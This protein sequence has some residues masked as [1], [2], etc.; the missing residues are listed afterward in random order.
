MVHTDS[1]SAEAIAGNEDLLT[2]ILSRIP[3]KQLIKFKSVSKSWLSLISTSTLSRIHTLK[4]P[5][6]SISGLFLRRTPT[7]FQFLPIHANSS[8]KPLF[9]PLNCAS[10]PAGIKYLQSCNG[11][12]LCSSFR[13]LGYKT[14][15]YV[16]NPTTNCFFTLPPFTDESKTAVFGVNLAFEPSKSPYYKVVCIDIYDSRIGAWRLS[17]STFIAPFDMVFD[18][19]VF[20]NGSIVW[21]SPH[22]ASIYFDL[23]NERLNKMSDLPV[24]DNWSKRRFRYFGESCGHLHLMEIYGARATRFKVFQLEKDYC[25]W[26]VKYEIDLE[27]VVGAY[28]EMV[29]SYLDVDDSNYYAFVP[30]VV[31]GDKNGV[32]ASLLLHIPGK[33]ISYNMRDKSFIELVAF[34]DDKKNKGFGWLDAYPYIQSLAPVC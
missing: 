7:E 33:I 30:L 34:N 28:S 31:V 5:S 32:D 6:S 4:N 11:L 15:Y 9:Y 3:V 26:T 21:I 18:N 2:E 19:G 25:N 1:D 8:L 16:Y 10:D 22:G 13:K 17:G 29:R 27:G 23:T 24:L 12:V 20:W 14:Q